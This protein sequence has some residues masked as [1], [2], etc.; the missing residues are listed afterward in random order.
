MRVLWGGMKGGASGIVGDRL[1]QAKGVN[2]DGTVRQGWVFIL[3]DRP[4]I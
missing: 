1:G 3:G 4:S 2:T